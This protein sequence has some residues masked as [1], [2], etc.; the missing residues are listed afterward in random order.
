MAARLVDPGRQSC[1]GACL[2]GAAKAAHVSKFRHDHH[3]RVKSHAM[4]DQS[5]LPPAGYWPRTALHPIVNALIS[6]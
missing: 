5:G 1:I 3:R 4:Q 2:F 6:F